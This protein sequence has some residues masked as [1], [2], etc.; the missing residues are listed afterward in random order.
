MSLRQNQAS[1]R[2]L[3]LPMANTI[4]VVYRLV[5]LHRLRYT[6]NIY[7][8]PSKTWKGV[9][10]IAD[11]ILI[12]AKG[13]NNVEAMLDHDKNLE[14]LLQSCL[15]QGIVLN[16]DKMRLRQTEVPYTGLRSSSGGLKPDPAKVETIIK[17]PRPDKP[18]NYLARLFPKL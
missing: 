5:C 12:C 4:G 15:K 8:R 13:Q 6:R 7:T 17:M 16:A 14:E 18:T 9:L 3:P 11:D 10:C 1:L 2:H